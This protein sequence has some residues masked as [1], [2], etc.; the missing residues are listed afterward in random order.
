VLCLGGAGLVVAMVVGAFLFW[1]YR[2][3]TSELE[4]E[5]AEGQEIWES[6]NQETRES[7]NR[8]SGN[9][10]IGEWEAGL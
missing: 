8:E 1:L 5:D 3:G 9:L 4:I 6:G 2:L 10:V 7:G